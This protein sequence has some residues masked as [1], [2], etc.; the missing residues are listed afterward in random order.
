MGGEPTEIR[1]LDELVRLIRFVADKTKIRLSLL[2]NSKWDAGLWFDKICKSGLFG[3]YASVDTVQGQSVCRH[4]VEKSQAGYKMLL[5][6]KREG[7]IPVL[8]ANVVLSKKNYKEVP[9]LVRILSEDGF[10]INICSFQCFTRPPT[11]DGRQITYHFRKNSNRNMLTEDD[12]PELK[13]VIDELLRLQENGAK[14]A[15]PR[16]YI[17]NIIPE[18]LNGGRWQCHRFS[19]LRID[20]DGT[21][22]ICNEFV[23]QEGNLPNL[24]KKID[25]IDDWNRNFI[26]YW[27][28]ER[29][30]FSCECYWSCFLQAE[31]NI[32]IGSTEFGFYDFPVLHGIGT[33][34]AANGEK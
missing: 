32:E 34:L 3:Y 15:V 10:F 12:L 5:D 28:R 9:E 6:M 22:M 8:A 33:R 18:G 23:G 13:K 26:D 25:S 31:K 7:S 14:I 4:S 29:K 27:Y 17:N 24:S 19:Q 1:D 20:S 11:Y 30:K 16:D 2:S 21:A